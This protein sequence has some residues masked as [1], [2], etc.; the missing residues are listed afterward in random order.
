MVRHDGY[1]EEELLND[2][3]DE[4]NIELSFDDI[5]SVSYEDKDWGSVLQL[6]YTKDGKEK[7]RH[8]AMVYEGSDMYHT[9]MSKTV[10]LPLDIA[11]KLLLEGKIEA[12]GVHI[13]ITPEFYNPILSELETLGFQF[14]E[15]E[16]IL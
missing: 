10:G 15:E 14:I 12:R 16:V 4:R 6:E 2:V 3:E 13:P 9:A 5:T 1:D 8:S 11:T 7:E